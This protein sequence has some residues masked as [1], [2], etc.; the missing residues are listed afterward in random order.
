M[1]KEDLRLSKKSSEILANLVRFSMKEGHG[2]LWQN[3]G[4]ERQVF[5][6]KMTNV[7]VDGRMVA[8]GLLED[9]SAYSSKDLMTSFDI[10]D[11]SR[12]LYFKSEE[13]GML[14][15][16]EPGTFFVNNELIYLPIP[17]SAYFKEMRS[18]PR[19]FPKEEM[20]IGLRKFEKGHGHQQVHLQCRNFSRGGFGLTLSYGNAHLF[21]KSQRIFVSSLKGIELP[22]PIE[23]SVAYVRKFHE[24]KANKILM[25]ISFKKELSQKYYEALSQHFS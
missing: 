13:K 5:P 18:N 8:F 25:G 21:K 15:K 9:R 20:A 10:I 7:L 6:V 24:E 3:H 1:I 19:M 11:P 4:L 17:T 14:F 2:I 23:G 12:Q 22:A 16:V